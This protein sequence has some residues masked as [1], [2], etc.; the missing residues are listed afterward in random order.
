MKFTVELQSPDFCF[1]AT[2]F[3]A[4]PQP[5]AAADAPLVGEP[6]HEHR[7]GVSVRL[8]GPLDASGCVVDFEVARRALLDALAKWDGRVVLAR[9]ARRVEYVERPDS[10]VAEIHWRGLP[11]RADYEVPLSSVLWLDAVNASTEHIAATLLEEWTTRLCDG[12]LDGE[13]AAALRLEEARGS[14]VEVSTSFFASRRNVG[15]Q[16]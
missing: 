16:M 15:N 3:V 11:R 6:L 10:D 12:A 14:F 8:T 1:R 13:Y 7:F 9:G 2:H 5:G 4:F